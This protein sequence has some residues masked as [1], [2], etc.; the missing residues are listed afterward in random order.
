DAPVKALAVN[1][2]ASVKVP[3]WQQCGGTNYQGPT[4]CEEGFECKETDGKYMSQCV[5]LTSSGGVAAGVSKDAPVKALAVN[6]FASVKVP[7]WQQCGGTNYQGPTNCE[8]GF[9]CKETD[10]KYMSQCVALTSSGGVAA[11]V[12]KDA[13]VK[14]LAV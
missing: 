7:G 10:G 11:G 9:E 12:S 1:S 13:P 2:F 8:E 14:A 5:A 6:S 4:N 3:G